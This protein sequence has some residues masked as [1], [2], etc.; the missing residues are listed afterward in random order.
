MA[1]ENS[2]IVQLH[3]DHGYRLCDLWQFIDDNYM[4]VAYMGDLKYRV[5]G[6]DD[7][8]LFKITWGW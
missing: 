6:A 1:N 3:T 2:F 7:A 8:T 4:D 5:E